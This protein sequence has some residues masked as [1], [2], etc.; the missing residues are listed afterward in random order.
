MLKEMFTR[1]RPGWV[2]NTLVGTGR[3]ELNRENEG[4]YLPPRELLSLVVGSRG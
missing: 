4:V 2:W 3:P 1:L